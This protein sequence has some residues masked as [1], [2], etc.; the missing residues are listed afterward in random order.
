MHSGG[1]IQTSWILEHY[2]WYSNSVAK[3]PNYLVNVR[4][5]KKLL[6]VCPEKK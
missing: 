1:L 5:F 4:N 2:V 3:I 6:S